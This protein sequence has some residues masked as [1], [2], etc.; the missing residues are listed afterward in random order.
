MA[1]MTAEALERAQ[2][3]VDSRVEALAE[4]R[5][6]SSEEEQ[7]FPIFD[8]IA[9]EAGYL[10]SKLKVAWVLK[11]PYD[12]F[13][14]DGNPCGGGWSL[15]KDCFLKHDENWVDERGHCQWKNPVWQK[16]AYVMY[17]FNHGRHWEDMDRIRDNPGMMDEIKYI[18]WI[19]LSKMPARKSSSDGSYAY[20]YLTFWK[21]LVDW[22]IDVCRPDVLIFGKTFGSFRQ[23][24][25]SANLERVDSISNDWAEVWRC[26]SQYWVDTYHPGRKGGD[27]VNALIDVLNGIRAVTRR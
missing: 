6:L 26:G 15:V 1:N 24:H 23:A 4:E 18:A 16:I 17:G 21:E 10:A 27:Y 12:D 22:Q 14:D 2:R 13:G 20:M 11:E 5:G 8:G 7:L 3:D 19:N 9:D 25:E